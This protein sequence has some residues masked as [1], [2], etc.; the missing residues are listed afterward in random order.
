MSTTDTFFPLRVKFKKLS[1]SARLPE[2]AHPSDAAFDLFYD[3]PTIKTNP[4]QAEVV[5]LPTNIAIAGYEKVLDLS[6]TLLKEVPWNFFL[7]I[8]GRSGLAVKNNMFPIGGIIDASYTG[9]I[10][11]IMTCLKPETVITPGMKIAQL[12]PYFIHNVVVLEATEEEIMTSDR[13]SKGFGSTGT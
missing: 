7:K 13:G 3:G 5:L 2:K 1:S 11:V 10:Q 12:I 8:E 6:G 4:K 9:N